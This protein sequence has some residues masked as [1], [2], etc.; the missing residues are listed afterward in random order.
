MIIV[1]AIGVVMSIL[2]IVGTMDDEIDA[3]K[4]SVSIAFV[5][6]CGFAVFPIINIIVSIWLFFEISGATKGRK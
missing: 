2:A 3:N 4:G 6:C 5:A 1:W